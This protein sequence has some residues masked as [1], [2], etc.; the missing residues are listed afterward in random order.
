[1]TLESVKAFFRRL[2][3]DADLQARFQEAKCESCVVNLA[4][5]SGFV[6]DED[7]V[8]EFQ[9]GRSLDDLKAVVAGASDDGLTEDSPWPMPLFR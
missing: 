5:E 6:F 9:N 4:Q 3:S 1:M 7:A 8:L 2:R